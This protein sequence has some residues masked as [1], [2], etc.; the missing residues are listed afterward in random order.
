[1]PAVVGCHANLRAI[2]ATGSRKPMGGD[3]L[4]EGAVAKRIISVLAIRCDRDV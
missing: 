2:E 3:I 1:M 4:M